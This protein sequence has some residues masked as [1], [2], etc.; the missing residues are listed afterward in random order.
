MPTAVQLDD[1][2]VFERYPDIV[3][4]C[5]NIVHYRGL[6][7]GRLLSVLSLSKDCLFLR[8]E[9]DRT[10][11]RHAQGERIRVRVQRQTYGE[12]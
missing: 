2:E 4:S 9:E 10:A 5:D 12:R 3:I 6:A 11:F 1:R 8:P 7:A